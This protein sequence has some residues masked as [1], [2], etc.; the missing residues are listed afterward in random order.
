MAHKASRAGGVSQEG[1]EKRMK[2]AAKLTDNEVLAIRRDY[3]KV[4]KMVL[5][6]RYGVGP[7]TIMKIVR[8]E[9]Y[10]WVG[11]VGGSPE[12]LAIVAG[13]KSLL[14]QLISEGHVTKVENDEPLG[15]TEEPEYG[16]KA[17]P[18][19]EFGDE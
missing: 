19:L 2:A 8:G 12:S 14:D 18:E 5:A 17:G 3:G 1:A 6:D 13:Q 16:A 10:R 9:S 11:G 4:G 15:L 7:V